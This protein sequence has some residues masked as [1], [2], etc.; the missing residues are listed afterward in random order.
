MAARGSATAVVHIDNDRTRVTEWRFRPGQATGWHRHELDYVIVPL[1]DGK[2][3]LIGPDGAEAIAELE[4]GKPYFR[5]L[6]V[7]HDVV[8]ANDFDY[9]FIEVELK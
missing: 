1:R 5:D 7:A 6:G 4:A 9:A 2:L 3:R 8:N